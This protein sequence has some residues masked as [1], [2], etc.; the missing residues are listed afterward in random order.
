M[1]VVKLKEME[2]ELGQRKKLVARLGRSTRAI[3]GYMNTP[4]KGATI[5]LTMRALIDNEHESLR[6]FPLP[7]DLRIAHN[8]LVRLKANP[9]SAELRDY[10]IMMEGLLLRAKP[11]I[12]EAACITYMLG[13]LNWSKA[14]HHGRKATW[15]GGMN[16][17]KAYALQA[18]HEFEAAREFADKAQDAELAAAEKELILQLKP[19]IICNWFG[20]V[21]EQA[22]R[23]YRRSFPEVLEL[24]KERKCVELLRSFVEDNPYLWQAIFNGLELSSW[25]QSAPDA[26][27]FYDHL[28]NADP[29]FQSFDYSPGEVPSI[30]KEPGMKWFHDEFRDRL[31]VPT[32]PPILRSAP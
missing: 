28:K 25:F 3:Q 4:G 13:M 8:V 17:W 6:P 7:D 1:Y 20:V 24:L 19:T 10:L 12:A 16:N 22:K 2:K 27:W 18:E 26:L 23:G 9:G 15:F 21:A 32:N 31:H 30:A 14:F 11:S 5:S 29:G